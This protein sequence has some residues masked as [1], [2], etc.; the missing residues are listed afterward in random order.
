MLEAFERQQHPL[1][2]LLLDWSKAF[3]PVTFESVE[4][5]LKHFGV[6]PFF[7]KAVLSLY[8]NPKFRVR[9]SGHTSPTYRQTRGLRAGCPLSPYLHD[10]EIA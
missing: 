2:L 1:H 4:A 9:D 3:D 7:Q 6:P 5:A 10:V 8:S